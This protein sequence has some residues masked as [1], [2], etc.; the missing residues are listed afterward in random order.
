LV[1]AKNSSVKLSGDVKAV[2]PLQLYPK[3]FKKRGYNQVQLFS[4]SLGKYPKFSLADDLVYRK[5]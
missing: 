5:K 4:E 2:L 3:R 1:S